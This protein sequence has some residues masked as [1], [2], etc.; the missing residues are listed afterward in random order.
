MEWIDVKKTLP[1][2]C[3]NRTLPY[4]LAYH[5]VHRVGVA[6]F[7]KFEDDGIVEELE[8]EFE[9]NYI[10]SCHFIFNM[11]SGNYGI[12]YEDDI[13]IFARSPHFFNLGTVTHWMPLPSQPIIYDPLHPN[14]S[15]CYP[16]EN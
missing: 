14:E 4:V 8:E 7:W 16:W 2:C 9:D 10:C 13:D 12:Q 1:P 3:G 11:V 15:V 5:T 6:W